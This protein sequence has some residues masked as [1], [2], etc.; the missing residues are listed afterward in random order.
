[1]IGLH[2]NA[3]HKSKYTIRLFGNFSDSDVSEIIN[4]DDLTIFVDEFTN[5]DYD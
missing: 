3:V 1:M 2:C 4:D 5:F